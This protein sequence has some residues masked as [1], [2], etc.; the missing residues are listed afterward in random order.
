MLELASAIGLAWS[1]MAWLFCA[2]CAADAA[3]SKGRSM[4]GWLVLGFTF[5]PLALLAMA[6]FAPDP[7]KERETPQRTIVTGP[8]M[9]PEAGSSR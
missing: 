6:A 7:S 8:V 5:G 4:F 1:F 3:A 2:G 9:T